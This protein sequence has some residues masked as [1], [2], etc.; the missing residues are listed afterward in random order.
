MPAGPEVFVGLVGA[1]GTNLDAVTTILEQAFAHVGYHAELVRLS[2]FFDEVEPSSVEGWPALDDATHDMHLSTRMDAGDKFREA[3]DR[4]DALA[5]FAMLKIRSIRRQLEQEGIT[6]RAYLLRSLKHPDEVD[7]FR[8]VYGA[9]FYLVSAYSPEDTRVDYLARKIAQ[10]RHSED[11]AR[12]KAEA[13]NLVARDRL[14][15]GVT[16]GQGVRNTFPKADCFVDARIPNGKTEALEGELRRF[17]EIIFA[18]PYHSPTTDEHA[19]FHAQAAALRSAALGRQVGAALTTEQGDVIAVGCNEVPKPF[20]GQYWTGDKNDNRDFLRQTDDAMRMKS[21][22]AEQILDRLKGAD[23]EPGWLTNEDVTSEEFIAL[24]EGTR[25]RSL[26]EFERA[27]HAEMAALLDAARRGQVVRDAILYTTTFPCHECTRHVIAAGIGRVVYIEP[28]PKSLAP[29][30]HDDAIVID[31]DEPPP[32]KVRFEPFVGV[33]PPRYLELF[34]VSDRRDDEGVCL[35]AEPTDQPKTLKTPIEMESEDVT[36]ITC[37][38]CSQENPPSAR[39]CNACGEEIIRTERPETAG[40]LAGEP[41]VEKDRPSAVTNE[42]V[43]SDPAIRF[44]EGLKVALFR[45]LLDEKQVRLKKEV[46]DG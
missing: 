12:F 5:L 31:V 22:V 44:L 36:T 28:Y 19:M 9:N 25:A 39:F 15:E 40:S 30:L 10:D 34:K 26:I 11:A 33:A 6:R 2:D 29:T 3:L 13:I 37:E 32:D 17:V 18:H 45:N 24:I 41:D 20:G 16:Y 21:L 43:L 35:P 8:E 42:T 46:D 23:G 1:V 38:S 7:A 4:G 14:E 27:V